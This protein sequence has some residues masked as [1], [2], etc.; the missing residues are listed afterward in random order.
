MERIEDLRAPPIVG[1]IYLVPTVRYVYF[2]IL[3]DWPVIGPKHNDT[4]ILDF[5]WPHYHV[6]ARFVPASLERRIVDPDS[7]LNVNLDA[8]VGHAPLRRRT[9]FRRDEIEPHPQPV[10]RPRQC[11]RADTRYQWGDRAPIQR[12]RAAFWNKRLVDTPCGRVCPHKGAPV[13]SLVPVAGVITCPLHGLR[14]NAETG[15]AVP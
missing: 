10:L 2:D 3:A 9:D 12:L 5:P 11:R 7:Y 1:Q 6:D 4:E 13:D 15:E 8:V 14:F